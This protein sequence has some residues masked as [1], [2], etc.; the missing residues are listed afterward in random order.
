MHLWRMDMLKKIVE[1]N[2]KIVEDITEIKVTLARIDVT[3]EKNTESLVE[4]VK[5]TNLIEQQ[6][7]PVEKHVAMVHGALKFIGIV[8]TLVGIA[9][10]IVSLLKP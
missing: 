5:R 6:L 8:A 2:E 4:H 7:R 10:G 1:T 3:L 9:A